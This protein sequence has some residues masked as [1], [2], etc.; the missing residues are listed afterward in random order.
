[1][2]EKELIVNLIYTDE[3][4]HYVFKVFK[5]NHKKGKIGFKKM[6]VRNLLG[7]KAQIDELSNSVKDL[8]PS[9]ELD[10][11]LQEFMKPIG[12]SHLQQ[13]LMIREFF[14]QFIL[15]HYEAIAQNVANKIAPFAGLTAYQTV[16][17]VEDFYENR[18][19]EL[20][21]SVLENIHAEII[22]LFEEELKCRSRFIAAVTGKNLLELDR[23]LGSAGNSA[24]LDIDLRAV[25]FD[26]QVGLS[27]DSDLQLCEKGCQ[28]DLTKLGI[29]SAFLEVGDYQE[30]VR[31]KLLME[32]Q[33]AYFTYNIQMQGLNVSF[34]ALELKGHLE[35]SQQKNATAQKEIKRLNQAIA[36]WEQKNKRE[37][38]QDEKLMNEIKALKKTI[39]EQKS[40]MSHYAQVQVAG[41][42]E[43]D[44]IAKLSQKE[45]ARL[46]SQLQ[47]YENMATGYQWLLASDYSVHEMVVLYNSPLLYAKHI[48]HELTFME[49]G[50]ALKTPFKAKK[51][52]V[53]LVGMTGKQKKQIEKLARQLEI[54]AIML[55][56][57]DERD[58][59][60]DIACYL[61]ESEG[62]LHESA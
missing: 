37:K 18:Y 35:S 36:E 30:T 42:E 19:D 9:R 55:E 20:N 5:D 57:V 54:E 7:S 12:I 1:M 24:E 22:K 49:V 53:Q 16:E 38:K 15:D 2:N 56:S 46:K 4:A 10:V 13:Y 14:P 48:Y 40:K 39:D 31:P 11:L 41:Q 29:L 51:M 58:L 60:M 3:D 32:L 52:L 25:F 45:T 61:K 44:K 28:R 6:R 62:I 21:R 8:A 34:Y 59:I 50:D 23:L 33:R 17:E 47:V 26:T 43:L 27:I